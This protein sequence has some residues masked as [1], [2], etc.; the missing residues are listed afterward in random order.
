M[1]HLF[2]FVVKA[3]QVI[4]TV[5]DQ[6]LVWADDVPLTTTTLCAFHAVLNSVV[7]ILEFDLFRRVSFLSSGATHGGVDLADDFVKRRIFCFDSICKEG[8]TLDGFGLMF[9]DKIANDVR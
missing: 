2:H 1:N 6:K 5:A 8:V 3:N 4:I 9:A 7:Q